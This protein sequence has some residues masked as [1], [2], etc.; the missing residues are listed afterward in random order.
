MF[1]SKNPTKLTAISAQKWLGL[2]V[3]AKT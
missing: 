3:Q 1:S 2:F